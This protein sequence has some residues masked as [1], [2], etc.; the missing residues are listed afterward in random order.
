MPRPRG[1]AFARWS[2]IALGVLLVAGVGIAAYR[3]WRAR[4]LEPSRIVVA[5]FTN[6]TGDPALEQ[7]GSMARP[8]ARLD[9]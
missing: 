5:V 2:L 4:R 1:P 3:Y 8:R 7:F 9:V 6:R